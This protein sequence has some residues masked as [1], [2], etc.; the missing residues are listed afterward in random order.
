VSP[1]V[2]EAGPPWSEALRYP[3]PSGLGDDKSSEEGPPLSSSSVMSDDGLKCSSE[4]EFTGLESISNHCLGFYGISNN[5]VSFYFQNAND[6]VLKSPSNALK[7]GQGCRF[8][9]RFSKF[10]FSALAIFGK[11]IEYQS[12]TRNESSNCSYF[13]SQP[14]E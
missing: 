1:T 3:S 10:S 8:I 4:K 11:I 13:S 6:M 5:F 12:D 9:D 7:D 2:E 14:L